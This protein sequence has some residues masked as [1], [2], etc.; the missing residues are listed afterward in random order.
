MHWQLQLET[1]SLRLLYPPSRQ[2]GAA[3]VKRSHSQLLT[4]VTAPIS[5]L[6]LNN[7]NT[8][9]VDQ[10]CHV[11]APANKGLQ[12][13]TAREVT[14]A[15]QINIMIE[16]IQYRDLASMNPNMYNNRKTG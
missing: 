8:V 6:A 10:P 4:L 2:A 12:Q 16:L 11:G 13:D 1:R 9:L 14:L 5:Y 3:P 7:L 15:V